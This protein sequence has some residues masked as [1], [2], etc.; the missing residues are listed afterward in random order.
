M[1]VGDG[2][3]D[4]DGAPQTTEERQQR[5]LGQLRA[6]N[7]KRANQQEPVVEVN[8]DRVFEAPPGGGEGDSSLHSSNGGGGSGGSDFA[9]ITVGSGNES[10]PT[11]P[12]SPDGGEGTGGGWKGESGPPPPTSSYSTPTSDSEEGVTQPVLSGR[13]RLNLE[14][15]KGLLQL[16]AGRTRGKA[17]AGALLAKLKLV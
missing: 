10:A 2:L 9:N 1:G 6:F 14:W 12:S 8:S 15:M 4:L 11:S 7:A 3:D 5:Y 16:I 13:D 17:R